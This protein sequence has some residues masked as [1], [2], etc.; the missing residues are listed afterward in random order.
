MKKSLLTLSMTAMLLQGCFSETTMRELPPFQVEALQVQPPIESQY[1]EFRGQVVTAEQTEL[2]F[3]IQGEISHLVVKPG[4]SVNKGQVVAKLVDEKLQQQYAD[5]QAQYELATKQLR[6]GTELY[7]REMVSSSELDELT[8]SKELASAQLRN[9]SHQIEYASLRAPFDGV[10]GDVQ[11]ERF[12]NVSPG[13]PVVSIY[14]DDKVY[15]QIS[16]SDHILA[17]LTPSNRESSYLPKAYFSGVEQPFVMR[18]LEHSSEPDSQSQTYELWLEMPQPDRKILPGTSVSI[19]VDMVAAGL[20]TLQGYQ[21][22]MTALQAG[23]KAGEF[24]IWKHQ[25]GMAKKV[26]VHVDQVNSNGVI[27]DAGVAQGD[28]LIHSNLRKLRDGQA[29]ALKGNN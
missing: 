16:L 2:S 10:I 18:Y 21:L 25:D 19:K 4:Q 17:S 8:S 13:E 1:R 12:E 20:S 26:M 27:V 29:V 3:R 22:P 11:K 7:K 5:A 15:V 24:Y 28:V 6:R 23:S 9:I 14:Q